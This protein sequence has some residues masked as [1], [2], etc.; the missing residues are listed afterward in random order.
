MLSMSSDSEHDAINT[1]DEQF[2][3]SM[4]VDVN[5]ESIGKV[6]GKIE[7]LGRK[8]GRLAQSM[9]RVQC[10]LAVLYKVKRS[11][12]KKL[13][14]K[15][16]AAMTAAGRR[17]TQSPPES[18]AIEAQQAPQQWV[19]ATSMPPEGTIIQSVPSIAGQSPMPPPSTS[20]FNDANDLSLIHI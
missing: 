13:R 14:A 1:E 11:I 4:E 9:G 17:A 18:P 3:A 16:Q 19:P 5:E 12:Q 10:R 20:I 8:A 2:V 15:Q 7:A 6:D